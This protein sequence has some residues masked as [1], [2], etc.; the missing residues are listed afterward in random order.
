MYRIWQ[1]IKVFRIKTM[2]GSSLS[3]VVWRLFHV[4]FTL[5]VF[6]L[7]IVV[8]NTCCV[9]LVASFSRLAILYCPI[10]Y[11]LTF[12]YL[13]FQ[14]KFLSDIIKMHL[15]IILSCYKLRKRY[16]VNPALAV[17]SIKQIMN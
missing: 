13:S 1:F 15:R 17:T 16:T 3:P 6:V 10:R 11:F 14:S 8:S 7:R 2:F 12:I 9:R 5:F 4:L